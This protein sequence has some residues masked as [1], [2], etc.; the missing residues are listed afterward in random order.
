[1]KSPFTVACRFTRPVAAGA[2]APGTALA[3]GAVLMLAA[4]AIAWPLDQLDGSQPLLAE[5]DAAAPGFAEVVAAGE[6]FA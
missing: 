2:I 6:V 3:I 5:K 4:L 1:M